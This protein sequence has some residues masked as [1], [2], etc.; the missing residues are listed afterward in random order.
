MPRGKTEP[1]SK[2][3]AAAAMIEAG[4]PC[5][6]VGK[7]LGVSHQAALR[8]AADPD[9]D[10]EI[11][12]R[13]KGRIQDRLIVASDRFLSASLD[14]IQDLHPYQAMLCAGIAHDHYLRATAAKQGNIGGNLTQILVLID[15]RTISSGTPPPS[16]TT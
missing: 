10:P 8:Y 15:Q 5:R 12:A 11:I 2:R 9:L 7:A 14:R 6:E 1:K 4:I 16:S 3:V 13:V